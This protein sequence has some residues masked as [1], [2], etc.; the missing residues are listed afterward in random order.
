M[1][2]WV[3]VRDVKA[4]LAARGQRR[5]RPHEFSNRI[6]HW[7]YCKHCGLLLIKNDATRRAAKQPCVVEE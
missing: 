2:D 7:P 3:R 6:L 1:S 5:S 4:F